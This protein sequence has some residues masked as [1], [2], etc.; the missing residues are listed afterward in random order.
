MGIRTNLKRDFMLIEEL[1][2]I[3]VMG[4]TITLPVLQLPAIIRD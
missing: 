3:P 1:V 2:V 4:V